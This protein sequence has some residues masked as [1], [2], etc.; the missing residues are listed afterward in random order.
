MKK[1][2]QISFFCLSVLL[3]CSPHILHA[4]ILPP[5]QPEQDAC[6]ALRICSTTFTSPYGYQGIGVVSDLTNTPCAGGEGNTMWL[7]IE[8]TTPG[9]IVFNL[10]PLIP[11]DDYDMAVLDITNTGCSNLTTANVIRCNFNNNAP[12]FNNGAIGLNTTSTINFAVAGVTGNSYLQQINANA[13]DVYLIMVNNFGTG[14]VYAPTSGFTIDFSGSTA[15]FT[16]PPPPKLAQ[17]IPYCNLSEQVTIQLNTQ[18]FCNSIAPDGSDFY[19]TPSGTVASVTGINCTGASGYT[20][21]IKVNFS[22]PLPNGDY[23]IHAKIGS[24]GNT[25]RGFC[26][27][28][29]IPPDSLNFHVGLDP[30]AMISLDSPACQKIKINL[31]TPTACASI[32]AN[33]TDF[34]ITGPSAVTISAAEGANCVTGGFTSSVILTLAAPIAVDGIYTIHSGIGSD[35]NTLYDS[36][37]R[38]LPAGQTINFKVNSFNGLLSALPDSI[39]CDIGST[40]NLYG[41]NNAPSPSAGFSYHWSPTT[42]VLYPNTLNTPVTLNSYFNTFLLTTVDGNGC[43]LRDTARID[44]KPFTGTLTP[45]KS[46]ICIGDKIVLHAGGGV[47]YNWYGDAA[48]YTTAGPTLD[49]QDCQE[50]TA[51]PHLGQTD[52]YVLIKNDRG[53]RDTLKTSIIVHPKPVIESFPADTTIKYGQSITLH[54]FGGSQYIW[55]PTATMAFDM[56]STPRVTPVQPTAYV[57]MGMNEF[58]CMGF[59]TSVVNLDF[60]K[61]TQLPNAFSPNGDGLND[62]F[63]IQNIGF[64]KLLLFQV[65]DRWGNKLFDTVNP[66]EGWDGSYKG[67]SADIGT[68][69]YIIKLGYPND[70]VETYR[71]D[72]TLVR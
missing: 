50:P 63:K 15:G 34:S 16:A 33:G 57:V 71:G 39:V 30:I 67:K 29:L 13:G 9:T 68:Y 51:E 3:L 42:G 41:I 55:S 70:V 56:T 54:A 69:Y 58:G 72:V 18:V 22:S 48:L 52:Y 21:K 25:L 26:D 20:N 6:N 14:P 37:G 12:V 4:Q 36:C 10:A 28:L 5:N 49:C 59:D 7:R 47:L 32:A 23:S 60:T 2:L 38:V 24:D 19:I 11:T 31:N 44:V 66:D 1:V 53:C 8:I 46:E 61:E 17:I 35:G 65:F 27:S 43:Y 45:I 64:R 40:V 62:I